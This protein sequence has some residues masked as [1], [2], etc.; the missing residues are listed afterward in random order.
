MEISIQDHILD[1]CGAS[2]KLTLICA[3]PAFLLVASIQS[4]HVDID[5]IQMPDIVTSPK[6][7]G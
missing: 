2:T 6:T 3:K 1:V 5:T 4:G 7:N